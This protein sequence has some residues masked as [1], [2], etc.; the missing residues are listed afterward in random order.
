MEKNHPSNP[1]KETAL[2][3]ELV[4]I[5]E[6]PEQK[7]ERMNKGFIQAQKRLAVYLLSRWQS[8]DANKELAISLKEIKE[9]YFEPLPPQYIKEQPPIYNGNN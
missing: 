2:S 8:V 7:K 5:I 6:T 1:T 4:H 9:K 3:F